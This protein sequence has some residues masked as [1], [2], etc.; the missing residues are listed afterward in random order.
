MTKFTIN[1]DIPLP[2]LRKAYKHHFGENGKVTKSKIKQ[3]IESLIDAD[4][5]DVLYFVET[6]EIEQGD[7]RL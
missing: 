7:P 4:I 1:V 3:W 2:M 5:Q 6:G